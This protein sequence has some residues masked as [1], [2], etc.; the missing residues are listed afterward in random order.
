MQFKNVILNHGGATKGQKIS[1]ANQGFLISSKK[2]MNLN[3]LSREDAQDIEF[4]SIF[5]RIEDITNCF[6]N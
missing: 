6:Q 4:S 3:I 5:G 2:R 1:R